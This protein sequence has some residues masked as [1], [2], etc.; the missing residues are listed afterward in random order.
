MSPRSGLLAPGWLHGC[1]TALTLDEAMAARE[2]LEPGEA[3]YVAAGHA[4]M[5]HS[6]SFYAPDSEQAGLLARAQE[7]DNLDKA[8]RA[9]ALIS[10]WGTRHEVIDN[11]LTRIPAP[12]EPK[13]RRSSRHE[14]PAT[15]PSAE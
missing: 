5:R 10:D 12:K 4:V 1:H 7:I 3:I 6:V 15:D 14:S 2:R 13:S 9:Q 8:F 11:P